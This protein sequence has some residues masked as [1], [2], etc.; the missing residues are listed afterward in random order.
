MY[1]YIFD[2]SHRLSSFCVLKRKIRRRIWTCFA[3]FRASNKLLLWPDFRNMF[4]FR[5]MIWFDVYMGTTTPHTQNPLSL[6]IFLS[7]YLWRRKL[8]LMKFSPQ[9]AATNSIQWK[10]VFCLMFASWVCFFFK[11]KIYQANSNSKHCTLHTFAVISCQMTPISILKIFC[12]LIQIHFEHEAWMGFTLK[13][14]K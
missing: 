10:L 5:I 3:L 14:Y 6:F 9:I 11:S 1:L 12:V 2:S 13:S 4:N 7:V 8:S